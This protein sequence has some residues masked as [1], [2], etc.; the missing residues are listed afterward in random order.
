MCNLHSKCSVTKLSF[1]PAPLATKRV[2]V[3]HAYGVDVA[4]IIVVYEL[5]TLVKEMPKLSD[6]HM[7]LYLYEYLSSRNTLFN[8]RGYFHQEKTLSCCIQ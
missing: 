2:N 5:W 4:T 6:A 8:S 1:Y 7:Y 3:W